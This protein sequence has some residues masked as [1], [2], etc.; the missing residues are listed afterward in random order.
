MA[1]TWH[2]GANWEIPGSDPGSAPEGALRNRS[3]LGEGGS[4]SAQ[5]NWEVLQ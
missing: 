1:L 5:G 2:R 4:K 3:A